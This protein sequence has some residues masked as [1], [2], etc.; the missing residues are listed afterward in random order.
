MAGLKIR[1]DKTC[2]YVVCAWTARPSGAPINVFLKHIGCHQIYSHFVDVASENSENRAFRARVR[3]HSGP[4]GRDRPAVSSIT[5]KSAIKSVNYSLICG[6]I[7][8]P[9]LHGVC[10]APS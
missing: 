6:K 10:A 9:V 8:D 3:V 4:G 7:S 5:K 2:Y 1:A